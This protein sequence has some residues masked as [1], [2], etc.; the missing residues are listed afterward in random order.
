MLLITA[1]FCSC[2]KSKVK[3]KVVVPASLPNCW[4]TERALRFSGSLQS[5]RIPPEFVTLALINAI[6][7]LSLLGS[8]SPPFSHLPNQN[9]FL[10][11]YAVFLTLLVRIYCFII[12][13]TNILKWVL[14]TKDHFRPM[15]ES[16]YFPPHNFKASHCSQHPA[17]ASQSPCFGVLIT[18][19]LH[20]HK[21]TL[22]WTWSVSLCAYVCVWGGPAGRCWGGREKVKRTKEAFVCLPHLDLLPPQDL[23]RN[24]VCGKEI[25]KDEG[26]K[27]APFSFSTYETPLSGFTLQT[28]G[29]SDLCGEVGPRVRRRR[30]K[31]GE[32]KS[33][34]CSSWLPNPLSIIWVKICNCWKIRKERRYWRIRGQIS[35]TTLLLYLRS[36]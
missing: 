24:T 8:C 1:W 2:F 16:F 4:P 29:K 11:A 21:H 28:S 18:T 19:I 26:K 6:M 34:L 9:S 31:I 33:H 27:V 32:K 23:Q 5:L 30:Q 12:L 36:L 25:R 13:C 17:K 20:T 35:S 14:W 22:A 7:L 10:K 3:G 15:I